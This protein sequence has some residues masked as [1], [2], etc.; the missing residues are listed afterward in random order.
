VT[1]LHTKPGTEMPYAARLLNWGFAVDGKVRPVGVLVRPL[2][3]HPVTQPTAH[4]TPAH[5]TQRALPPPAKLGVPGVP[6][7]AG[8]GT[9]ALALLTSLVIAVVSRRRRRAESMAGGSAPGSSMSGGST[10]G[11]GAP[12]GSASDGSTPGGKRADGS[13]A[14]GS[15]ATG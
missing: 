9:L 7:L 2:P 4:R 1:I 8:L 13:E 15:P 14:G 12:G 11:G 5:H 6:L 10:P 3:A